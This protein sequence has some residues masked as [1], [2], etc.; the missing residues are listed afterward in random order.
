MITKNIT[1][2]SLAVALIAISAQITISLAWVPFTLQIFCL[3]LLGHL[4]TPNEIL[5]TLCTYIVLGLIGFP[6]FAQGRGGIMMLSQPSFGFILG[7]LPFT[8]YIKTKPI[9]AYL[10]L[11]LLGLSVLI[12]VVKFVYQS[13]TSIPILIL[14][15]AIFFLPTDLLSILIA[16][17]LTRKYKIKQPLN[18]T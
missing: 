1:R 13:P 6:L 14:Q 3:A 4:L 17:R 10:L 8:Y 9:Q 18:L 15:N 12:I 5:L 7:F 2:A 11:Y 16:K